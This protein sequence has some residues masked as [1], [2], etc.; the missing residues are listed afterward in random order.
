MTYNNSDLAAAF[1]TFL[2]D[3]ALKMIAVLPHPSWSTPTFSVCV[4]E[5]I[6]SIPYRIYH[7]PVLIDQASLTA[8]QVD[9]LGCLLTRHHD[10][11]V[12]ERYL[13]KIVCANNEW[14]PPF[15][16]QLVG[17]YVVEILQVVKR[18]LHHLDPKLYASF[19]QAN[20][21]FFAVTK[22][23]VASYWNCY[24]RW[25]QRRRDYAGFEIVEFLDHLATAHQ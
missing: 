23:R 15:V 19:L 16:V 5:Q 18:N 6:V 7:D 10:G 13:A 24:Y 20:P 11:F 21:R 25:E 12:R 1:P 14:T 3:D 4:R 17:E 2:R 8:R 22:Q 9:M